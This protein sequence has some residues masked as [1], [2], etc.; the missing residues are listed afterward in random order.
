MAQAYIEN[1]P[2]YTRRN[3]DKLP[4]EEKRQAWTVTAMRNTPDSLRRITKLKDLVADSIGET[5]EK[6]AWT[7][8]YNQAKSYLRED[9]KTG[10]TIQGLF[11]S[12]RYARQQAYNAAIDVLIGSNP[13]RY[14][15]IRLETQEDARVRNSH[16]KW[17]GV[18]L[19]VD[20][21]IWEKVNLP[22]DFNCRCLKVPLEKGDM[23]GFQLT[24]EDEIPPIPKGFE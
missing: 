4:D 21:P 3:F 16:R 1:M 23:K 10:A 5:D 18:T 8:Y 11:V 2:T 9:E 15:A 19:P 12:F 13:G 7:A 14:V 17:E 24:P 22:F 20:H 6:K